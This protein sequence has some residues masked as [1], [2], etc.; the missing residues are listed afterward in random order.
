ME[1]HEIIPKTEVQACFSTPLAVEEYDF[2]ETHRIIATDPGNVHATAMNVWNR[3][4]QY[5][6]KPVNPGAIGPWV[7]AKD[8]KIFK[9]IERL[10]GQPV[11]TDAAYYSANLADREVA[12]ILL[13]RVFPNSLHL[14]DVFFRNPAAPLPPAQRRTYRIHKGLGLLPTVFARMRAY[15]AEQ[16]IEFLTLTAAAGDLVPLFRK[17]GFEIE[18]NDVARFCATTDQCIPMEL[19]IQ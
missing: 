17:H 4:V 9:Q 14:A 7:D 2:S 6:L 11:L 15:A 19:K 8:P 5:K 18:D 1:L 16:G 12:K 10:I 13:F 3:I